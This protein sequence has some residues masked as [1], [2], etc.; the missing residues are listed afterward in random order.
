M[1]DSRQTQLSIAFKQFDP[2]Y[3]VQETWDIQSASN[4]LNQLASIAASE[5][6]Q[7]EPDHVGMIAKLMIALTKFI[8]EEISEMMNG[9]SPAAE[10]VEGVTGVA[11][12][13]A[14]PSFIDRIKAAFK[15]GARHNAADQASVQDIHDAAAKLGADCSIAVTKEASGAD[16]WILFSSNSYEDKEKEIVSQAAQEADCARMQETGNYGPLRWRHVGLP[17]PV[18]KEA[19]P[20]LDIGQC[21]FSAMHGRVRIES[22][23]FNSPE[24]AQAVKEQADQFRS[25]IGFFHPLDQP[26]TEGVY[27]NIHTFERSLTTE[28][29]ASNSLTPLSIIEKENK[30]MA[31]FDEKV[32]DFLS[33]FG[34]NPAVAQQV[35]DLAAKVDDAAKEKGLRAKEAGDTPAPVAQVAPTIDLA[36]M[37][38]ALKPVISAAIDEK[39]NALKTDQATKEISTQATIKTLSD[40]LA[41]VTASLKELQ[42]EQPRGKGFRASTSEETIIDKTVLKE[43]ASP[44][45]SFYETLSKITGLS[46]MPAVGPGITP[47][48]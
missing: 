20:G 1:T 10:P 39:F 14:K 5:A 37:A 46:E 12:M 36:A 4:A 18:T 24:L 21:D 6:S 27:H 43:S 47:T 19:G 17:N 30:N 28:R 3:A 2:A 25:S 7:E 8:N 15:A 33:H 26:N 31:S 34:D 35:K 41:T 32:K 22:G 40:Q 13:E 48:A 11:L 9:E 29:F 23:T 16:R 38:E 44:I 45:A 42:G